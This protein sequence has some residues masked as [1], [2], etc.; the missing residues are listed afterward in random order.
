MVAG[1]DGCRGGW[2]V[3][4]VPLQR[5]GPST[6]SVVPDLH[7]VVAAVEDGRLAAVAVDIPIG[8]PLQGPRAADVLARSRLGPRRSSVFPAPARAVLGAADHDEACARSRAVCGKGI[9]KQLYNILP[10]IA[11]ADEVL[12]PLLQE[13]IVEMCPELSF[14]ML[15]GSPLAHS[16]STPAGREE[17]R[18]A[19]ARMFDDAG[20]HAECPPPG[21]RADDVLDAFAGAW[22]ARRFATGAH[23]RFGGELDARG[24]RMEVIA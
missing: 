5:R 20:G 15:T 9:S 17:R 4:A 1:L 23:V 12:S 18:D 19:L 21:A 22:T 3:A 24:L 11:Q 13:Q 8:L 2:V 10:K 6:V 7:P 14:A 16:K